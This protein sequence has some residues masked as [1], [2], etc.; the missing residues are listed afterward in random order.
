MKRFFP[1]LG[2]IALLGLTSCVERQEISPYFNPE[3]KQVNTQFYLNI[4]AENSAKTKQLYH[5]VQADKSF[6]GL[7]SATLFAFSLGK[8]TLYLVSDTI[9]SHRAEAMFNLSDALHKDSVS[10]EKS[11]RIIELSLPMGTNSLIFYGKATRGDS[12]ADDEK[13]GKLNYV[14]AGDG[15][16]TDLWQVGCWAAPRID[17][18]SEAGK[19]KRANFI[20]ME[21]IILDFVNHID[22][23]GFNGS[24]ASGS[25]DGPWNNLAINQYEEI[26]SF[27]NI[28]GKRVMWKDFAQCDSNGVAG[29]SPLY[30]LFYDKDTIVTAAPLEQILG[31]AYNSFSTIVTIGTGA[32]ASS[33]LRAGSGAAIARQLSDLSSVLTSGSSSAALDDAERVAQVVINI[34][35]DYITSFIETSERKWKDAASGQNPIKTA[36]ATYINSR[37]PD[38]PDTKY[39][40]S[41]FPRNFHLPFGATTLQ[42][43]SDGRNWTYNSDNIALPA[44]GDGVMTVYDYTYPPELTYY[45]N[46][47]IWVKNSTFDPDAMP[48]TCST[49]ENRENWSGWTKS[50]VESS[51]R[52][53]A[54]V[55]NIQYGVS[56]LE[57]SVYCNGTLKDNNS[58]IH[59]GESDN[60]FSIDDSHYLKLTGVLVGGQ[61]AF[62]GWDYTYYQNDAYLRE[63]YEV[64]NNFKRMVYDWT[65][66]KPNITTSM[67]GD[68]ANCYTL[69]FDNWAPANQGTGNKDEVYVSL[70]FENH[71]GDDFWGMHNMV[72]EGGTFYLI[73][74]LR[75]NGGSDPSSPQ[76]TLQ[77][78]INWNDASPI[79]PHKG[80]SRVFV[81]DFITKAT[82]KVTQEAL[83]KAY[84]TVPDLR[85][86]KLSFGL[87]VNLEWATG[88][89]FV[90]DL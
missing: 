58:G 90:V 54:L 19:T 29:T 30:K 72:R 59:P 21:K 80:E 27:K 9:K 82:F 48:N 57:T 39:T 83:K 24:T 65:V 38:W 84:V 51:T 15:R 12:E 77:T 25:E 3:T 33:E 36:Y 32:D 75:I 4:E 16:S 86:A 14:L 40:F 70:E 13:Y 45:G 55:D 5:D 46:G 50:H 71:L 18:L 26:A 76:S 43:S 10:T 35:N 42:L 47:P 52:G 34:L 60:V 66:Q 1:L 78:G 85:T 20:R 61:P 64:A 31:K 49:W 69:V 41:D 23:V 81:Q 87:S 63:K 67:P 7:S 89:A 79:C 62:V 17:T 53:V 56:M 37:L 2:F 28:A 88:N 22:S 44:M 74:C 11:R 73:G 6:G 68:T 8:D